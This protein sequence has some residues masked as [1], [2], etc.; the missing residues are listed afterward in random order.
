[1]CVR[2]HAM[3][4]LTFRSSRL[5]RGRRVAPSLGPIV[6]DVLVHFSLEAIPALGLRWALGL[7]RHAR[8]RIA[9]WTSLGLLTSWLT[10]A[11]IG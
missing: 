7:Y 1:M 4:T 2:S 11:M 8:H 9:A 6:L 3:P 5:R 10:V